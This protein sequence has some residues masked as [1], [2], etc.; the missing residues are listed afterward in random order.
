MGKTIQSISILAYLY[1]TI[2]IRNVPHL[3]VVPKSAISNWKRELEKWVP[4]FRVVNL[5]STKDERE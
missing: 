5:V 3:I 2:K 1:E 4:F